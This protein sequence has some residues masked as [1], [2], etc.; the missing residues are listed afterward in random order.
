MRLAQSVQRALLRFDAPLVYHRQLPAQRAHKRALAWTVEVR[1]EP[2]LRV[3]VITL[4][5]PRLRFVGRYHFGAVRWDDAPSALFS[6]AAQRMV[7]AEVESILTLFRVGELDPR[8]W[9]SV[10]EALAHLEPARRP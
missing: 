9:T 7:G 3:L 4:P 1:V 5:Q 6:A 2:T 8:N 10:R